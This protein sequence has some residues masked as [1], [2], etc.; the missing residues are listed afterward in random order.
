MGEWRCSSTILVLDTRRRGVVSFTSRP[1]YPRGNAP[2]TLWIGRWV[3]PAAGL[4]NVEKRTISP[5]VNRTAVIIWTE[6][7]MDRYIVRNEIKTIRALHTV[8]YFFN[9]IVFKRMFTT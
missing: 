4:D 8:L 3:G 9:S 7:L 1:L 5:A 6:M 2:G